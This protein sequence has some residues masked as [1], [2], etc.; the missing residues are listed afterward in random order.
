MQSSVTCFT[1]FANKS[2]WTAA[3]ETVN[4]VNT[5]SVV[6]TRVTVA[7]IDI[8]KRR[9]QTVKNGNKLFFLL[10]EFIRKSVHLSVTCFASVANKSFWTGA[11]EAVWLIN[12]LS[13]VQTRVTAAFTDI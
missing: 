3:V 9:T 11:V 12:T 4:L 13:V 7:F 8:C 2:S 5:R 6:Q 1:S 10:N